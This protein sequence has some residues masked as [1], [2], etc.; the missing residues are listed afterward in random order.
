MNLPNKISI[1]RLCMTVVMVVLFLLGAYDI[2]PYGE[3][4]ATGVYVL[5]SITD[6]IDGTIARKCGLVTTLGKF[7]D[8]IA[9]KILCLAAFI[10]IAWNA[11]DV[12][13]APSVWVLVL[14]IVHIARDFM[15]SALR[16]I[17]ASENIIMAADKLG[18]VKA[19]FDYIAIPFMMV[20]P[21]LGE[22][23]NF[24]M[25]WFYLPGFILLGVA[26]VMSIVSAINYLVVNKSVFKEKKSIAVTESKEESAE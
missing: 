2:I 15:I 26:T 12:A 24:D 22:W 4:Y 7:L 18:K 25:I 11:P 21:A 6:G 13:Y 9:D 17:C 23:L 1:V 3:I 20:A 8:S 10:L 5:A 16:Q 14:V 19:V